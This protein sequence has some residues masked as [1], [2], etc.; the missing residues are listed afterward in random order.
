MTFGSQCDE[1]TS[2]GALGHA[3]EA[4][5]S[6]IDIDDVYPAIGPNRILD[7]GTASFRTLN[8]SRCISGLSFRR[9]LEP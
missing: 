8:E 4:G 1:V 2:H 7:V 3:L 6:F 9:R 5:I